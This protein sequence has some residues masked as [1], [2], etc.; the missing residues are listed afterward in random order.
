MHTSV[1]YGYLQLLVCRIVLVTVASSSP[2]HANGNESVL[3]VWPCLV[4]R[5]TM[6]LAVNGMSK[7]NYEQFSRMDF[8]RNVQNARKGE[9]LLVYVHVQ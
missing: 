9:M 7:V 6:T 5:P 3:T 8:I 1:T 4:P 2:N